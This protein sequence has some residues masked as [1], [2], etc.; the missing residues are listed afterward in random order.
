[1]ICAALGVS[2]ILSLRVVRSQRHLLIIGFKL[3][4]ISNYCV[5]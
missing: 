1:M 3:D 2:S 4:K 5:R